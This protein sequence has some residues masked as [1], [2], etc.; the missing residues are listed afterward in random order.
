MYFL[1]VASKYYF[2]YFIAYSTNY[3]IILYFIKIMAL[4][5]KISLDNNIHL[6]Q[7]DIV[8]ACSILLGKNYLTYCISDLNYETVFHLKHYYFENKVVGKNDFDE[9]LADEHIKNSK[10][11]N[12]AI[13][14]FKSV[15]IPNDFF[16]EDKKN[17]YFKHLHEL[18]KEEIV[19]VQ[20]F[21]SSIIDLYAVKKSSIQFLESRLKNVH[22]YNASACLL[23]NYPEFIIKEHQHS[24]FISIKDENIVITFYKQNNLMLHQTYSYVEANDIVFYIANISNQFNVDKE[25]IG[26]QLHGE[27]VQIDSVFSSLKKYFSNVRFTTRIKDIQYPDTLYAQPVYNFYNL[28]SIFKCAL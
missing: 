12:I 24:F 6:I 10:R 7:N 16:I 15:L 9:I 19:L 1:K 25:Q 23:N 27:V 18:N 4:V 22:F 8:L 11:V 21:K 17:S 28:F 26:I 3:F 14:S 20:R 13:D 2:Q 5:P